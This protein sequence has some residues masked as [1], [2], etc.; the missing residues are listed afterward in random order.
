MKE[1]ELAEKYTRVV[2][3][4]LGQWVQAMVIKKKPAAD[5]PE[6]SWKGVGR[7][8]PVRALAENVEL[9]RL[10]AL[11]DRR[12]FRLCAQCNEVRPTSLIQGS[13]HC[14]DCV[15]EVKKTA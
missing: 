4:N 6:V 7:M 5:T 13:G 15:D 10:S 8:L 14:L 1:T 3:T 12:F 11:K 9:A 2:K